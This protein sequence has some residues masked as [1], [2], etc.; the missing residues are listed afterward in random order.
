MSDRTKATEKEELRH[1]AVTGIREVRFMVEVEARS[2]LHAM[3]LVNSDES[4][5]S[6]SDFCENVA[7]YAEGAELND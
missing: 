5:V 6:H 2:A 4:L 3:K 7:T 1:Y